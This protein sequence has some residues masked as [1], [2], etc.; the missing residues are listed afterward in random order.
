MNGEVLRLL[1]AIGAVSKV[2]APQGEAI[3]ESASSPLKGPTEAAAH[4]RNQPPA[5]AKPLD[6]EGKEIGRNDPCHCGSGKK[7][8]KCHGV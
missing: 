8:K 4:E 1:P 7:F 6:A 2:E 3:H 5:K